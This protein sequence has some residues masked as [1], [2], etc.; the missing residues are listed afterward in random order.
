M[1]KNKSEASSYLDFLNKTYYNLHKK[2][3]DL[4]WISYM[5]DRSVDKRM[6]QALGARDKFR[7][8]NKLLEK[9][10]GLRKVATLVEKKRLGSWEEFFKRYQTPKQL[11]VMKNRIALLES[12]ILKERSTRKEGYIEPK[13]GKFVPASEVK[14]NIIIRTDPREDV[15]K[16]CFEATEELA[17]HHIKDYIKLVQL[18]NKYA[19]VLGYRDFYDFKL[20]TEEGLS[21]REL[22][23]LFDSIYKKTKFAFKNIRQL[24]KTNP[25]LREPWNFGFMMSG[26]LTKEE[27]PYFQFDEAL[28][29]WGK[30]F[31]RLGVD[32]KKG[33]LTLDLVDR[34]NKWNNGFCHWPKLVKFEN[35]TKVPGSSNFTCTVVPGQ[36][37]SGTDGMNTLFHEGGHAAH[38][39][40]SEQLDVCLNHEY[41]PMSTAWAETQSMFMDRI[42]SSVEWRSRYAENSSGRKYPFALFKRKTEKVHVL[43]PLDIRGILFVSNFEKE[44]YESRNLNIE[45]V[46]NIARKNYQKYYDH[47]IATLDALGVPH[48][49]SWESACAY[50]GYGLAVLALSQW[51][52]YFYKKYGYIVD[53]PR[54]GKEM[55]KV[56]ELGASKS[57]KDFVILAT[58]KPLS[59][60]AFLENVTMTLEKT[61]DLAKKRINKL[62]T[63][64][65][66]QFKI[67]LNADIHMVHGKKE[68]ANNK[69]SFEKMA[70]DY[71]KWLRK[72]KK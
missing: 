58:G 13:T 15:R 33:T 22:F 50:H 60:N 59:S 70:L 4:F 36:I 17:T 52:R 5:G 64:P 72:L 61:L 31:S 6:N 63:I 47:S 2:Y 56:W 3:E 10:R 16:S 38:M 35:E 69:E 48:I 67:D 39:L 14:M 57:F 18:R 53:N 40:N 26:S 62:K 34:K 51:R 20:A 65:K 66:K 55:Q 49:Y 71:K 30:S 21:K 1:S 46:K 8:D 11:L 27:D 24:E 9:V 43:R 68:I 19:K 42:F 25:G 23:P 54:I 44:I 29:R 45:K 37:G 7:A 41:P 28:L 12:K 32:F